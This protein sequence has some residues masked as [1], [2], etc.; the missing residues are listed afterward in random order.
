[1]ALPK[2]LT[3]PFRKGSLLIG[4][5]WRGYFTPYNSALGNTVNNTSLGVA[6]L[7]LQVTGPFNEA[8]PPPNFTDLGWITKFKLTPQSKIGSVRSGYR[9]AIRAQYRGQVGET[10]EFTFRES[11]RLAWKIATGTELFNLLSNPNAIA[12][13]LGPL[14]SSGATAV[15]MGA[16]GYQAAYTPP[17]YAGPVP[18]LFVPAGSGAAFPVG[19]FIV[20]DQDFLQVN[21]AYP[22]GIVGAAGINIFQNAVT[23]IDFYRKTSDFVGRVVAVIAGVVSG[24]DALILSN[25]GFIGGGNAAT[26]IVPFAPTAGAKVQAIKGFAAREGGSFITEWSGLFCMTCLDGAQIALY[27]PHL[28]PNQF[29]DLASWQI[30]NIGTTDETG[31]ELDCVMEALAYDDPIDG[32]TVVRYAA[33]YTEPGADIAA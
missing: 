19:S 1:M 24:Q 16:S 3:Q 6:V 21:G 10:V 11:T 17:T 30:E 29:K 25:T 22:Y 31:Y 9:G 8:S 18:T 33:Y 32:E 28:S 5:G 13:T 14:S 27:Y 7:D 15:A 4:A 23:D 12:S 2:S 20:C 26:G